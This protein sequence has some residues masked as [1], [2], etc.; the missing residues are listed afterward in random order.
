MAAI[1]SPLIQF[2]LSQNKHEKIFTFDDGI[3]NLTKKYNMD[4]KLSLLKKFLYWIV[5]NKYNKKKILLKS[6]DHFTIYKN[7]KNNFL[8]K[9]IYVGKIF[10]KIKFKGKKVCTLIIGPVFKD[11]FKPNEGKNLNYILNKYKFFLEKIAMKE[12]IYVINHPRELNFKYDFNN[13]ININSKYLAEDYI[14]KILSKKFKKIYIYS[15][16]VSTVTI[17]L[18]NIK[19]IKNFFFFS[20]KNAHRSF[21]SIKVVKKLNLNYKYLNLD[22]LK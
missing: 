14:L 18:R 20:K 21:E 16:P 12:K 6:S 19:F 17:N 15:F 22:K 10:N 1:D 4:F 13:I 9:S 3:G 5:G 7:K 8:K 11:L 2:I